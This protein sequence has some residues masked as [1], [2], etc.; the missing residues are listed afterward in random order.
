M[1]IS[2]TH[3]HDHTPIG[4]ELGNGDTPSLLHLF[5]TWNELAT[6][7]TPLIRY[8]YDRQHW[9]HTFD[10]PHDRIWGQHWGHTF[11][12]SHTTESHLIASGEVVQ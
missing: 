3:I 10:L 9:G 8:T 4:E 7:A 2:R 5:I 12:L 11:D 6:G 1:V